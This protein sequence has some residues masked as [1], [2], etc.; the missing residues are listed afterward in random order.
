MTQLVVDIPNDIAIE[1]KR[2]RFINWNEKLV[3]DILFFMNEREIVESILAKSKLK[4]EDIEEI[5]NLI[6]RDLFEKYYK[7]EIG[8]CENLLNQFIHKSLILFFLQAC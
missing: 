2:F 7:T 5:D 6:K 1:M 8:F 4:E 3:N